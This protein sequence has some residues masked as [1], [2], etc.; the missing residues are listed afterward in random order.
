M[1]PE[2]YAM[3]ERAFLSAL[4][5][6]SA[7]QI[8]QEMADSIVDSAKEI[9]DKALEIMIKKLAESTRGPYR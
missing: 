2:H 3:W 6:V 7:A 8:N 1:A 4:N 5:G 9:A